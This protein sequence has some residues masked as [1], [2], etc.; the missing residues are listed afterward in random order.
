MHFASEPTLAFPNRGRDEMTV[1]GKTGDRTACRSPFPEPPPHGFFWTAPVM[2]TKST[3]RSSRVW[4]APRS[5]LVT[6]ISRCT[7]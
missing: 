6:T 3:E 5:F 4:I 7:S 1:T 2:G